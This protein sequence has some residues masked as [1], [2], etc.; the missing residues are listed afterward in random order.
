MSWACCW[1]ENLDTSLGERA[2]PDP[3]SG[4]W[5][6]RDP[7]GSTGI[8]RGKL[9]STSSAA[10]QPMQTAIFIRVL[11]RLFQLRLERRSFVEIG[12]S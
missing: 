2:H 6:Q 7:K 9:E 10:L 4:D 8:H 12:P 3:E 5:V 11:S 1:E